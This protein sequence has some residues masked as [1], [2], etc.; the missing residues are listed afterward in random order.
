M[1]NQT[2]ATAGR[3]LHGCPP[4]VRPEL[5]RGAA[6]LRSRD[7]AFRNTHRRAYVFPGLGRART[8]ALSSSNMAKDCCLFVSADGA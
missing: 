3:I 2:P 1:G 4:A 8:R 5:P 6:P 7:S